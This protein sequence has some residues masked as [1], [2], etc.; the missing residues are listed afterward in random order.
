M[1]TDAKALEQEASSPPA[2]E[3]ETPTEGEVEAGSSPA[4]DDSPDIGSI[5]RDVVAVE[6]EP[7]S[8]PETVEETDP[9]TAETEGEEGDED[10]HSD[11]PFHEHP[12]FKQVV[13][14]RRQF[15]E[16]AAQ[17]K[18]ELEQVRPAAEQYLQVNSFLQENAMT[19]DEA[20]GMLQVAAL[21]KH[22]PVA[23]YAEGARWFAD[24]AMRAGELLPDDLQ[25][26]VAAGTL[27]KAIA[28]EVARARAKTSSAEAQLARGQAQAQEREQA[29]RAQARSEEVA[30][31]GAERRARDPK[32]DAK[33]DALRKEIHWLETTMPSGTPAE[34]RAL[35]DTAYA[36]VNG[37]AA[38]APRPAK[39][40]VKPV[41]GGR[42]A[43]NGSDSAP[44]NT[45]DLIKSVVP[46]RG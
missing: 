31:W 45:M 7:G 2:D 40:P 43:G 15:K 16:E 8:S 29:Q 14:E 32:F 42:S 30:S 39:K 10:D 6:G 3:I 26:Q 34:I 17:A 38:P 23:A 1:T 20:A 35:L 22:N 33:Y 36:N 27:P 44:Q 5:I 24:L 37:S 25:Q 46:V 12:R 9:E 11:V 18:A 28:Q 41:V 21:A 4:E 19:A 13:T